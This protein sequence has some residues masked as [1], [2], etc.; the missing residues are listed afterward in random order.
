MTRLARFRWNRLAGYVA[1][2]SPANVLQLHPEPAA[3]LP[4]SS[5]SSEDK[6][7][8][9]GCSS[10]A[11]GSREPR[12]GEAK[13]RASRP[14]GPGSGD[15]HRSAGAEEDGR[16]S[17][18]FEAAVVMS[19]LLAAAVRRRS[20]GRGQRQGDARQATGLQPAGGEPRRRR[21]R[22]ARRSRQRLLPGPLISFRVTI[23]SPAAPP[24]SC[25]KAGSAQSSAVSGV[26]SRTRAPWYMAM[27]V[28]RS[29]LGSNLTAPKIDSLQRRGRSPRCP[30]P[31][32]SRGSRRSRGWPGTGRA[33]RSGGT[34]APQQEIGHH[35]WGRPAAGQRA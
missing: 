7:P 15:G 32:G 34:R 9:V 29:D 27:R 28:Q 12:I 20:N 25:R 19:R 35:R 16:A 23:T 33:G 18:P 4:P 6:A 11:G 2:Q 14:P 31:A 13:R 17:L 3:A 10:R 8:A 1:C 21:C 22:P 26:S 30:R 24:L 5:S